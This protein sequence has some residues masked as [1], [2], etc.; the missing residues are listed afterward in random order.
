MKGQ[1]NEFN[2][3]L[4]QKEFNGLR[5]RCQTVKIENRKLLETMS[6][7]RV[8]QL[9]FEENNNDEDI[10]DL[11]EEDNHLLK[12]L[13]TPL[14][15]LKFKY[16]SEKNS[17]GTIE[18][19]QLA[20]FTYDK[21]LKSVSKIKYQQRNIKTVDAMVKNLNETGKK[22]YMIR[23]DQLTKNVNNENDTSNGAFINLKNKQFNDKLNREK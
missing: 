3:E 22:R 7:P 4:L 21:E 17:L 11:N 23:K 13:T 20:K 5:R 1:D 18:G 10:S 6:K 8:Y 9:D 2:Y 15:D 19:D 12:L 16:K 14:R